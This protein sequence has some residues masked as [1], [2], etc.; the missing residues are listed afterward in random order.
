MKKLLAAVAMA[1][2]F[3]LG[4]AGAG[5]MDSATLLNN[6][7]RYR[8][9]STQSDGVVYVDM[10]SIRSIQTRDYPNSIENIS[11]TLY[12]EKYNS[13]LDAM[14]FQKNEIIG[15]INEY[16][17]KLHGNKRENTYDIAAELQQAY[18][19]DG[20]A[21]A[22][23]IDTIQFKNIKE[24]FINTHRL[25]TDIPSSTEKPAAQGK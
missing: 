16:K 2:T 10:E 11:C 19:P 7:S 20:Q 1:S 6:P 25:A 23:S 12:V 22:V 24:L 15:Q 21:K 13:K 9:V 8:V 4:C 3:L 18:S 17:A 5:A 14:A